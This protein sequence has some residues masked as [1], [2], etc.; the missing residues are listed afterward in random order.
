MKYH[1]PPPC[2]LMPFLKKKIRP[3]LAA[4]SLLLISW[5]GLHAQSAVS[6]SGGEA[7]GSGGSSS[8]T[9]GQV[10][11]TTP[12]GS[13]GSVAQG[14]QQP[15]EISSVVGFE[16]DHLL[17]EFA[18]FPNPTQDYLTLKV[19]GMGVA[20]LGYQLIDLN[21]RELEN[22]QLLSSLTQ[23]Q[24]GHLS[25]STYFLKVSDGKDLLRTFKIIKN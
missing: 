9:I 17:L 25:A 20:E 15:Y 7:S 4:C 10:A 13:S 19:E 16:N 1:H 5:G 12:I 18:A 23:I 3:L 14:V 24:M 6:A 8:Y 2:E 22:N 11:Y 21:G